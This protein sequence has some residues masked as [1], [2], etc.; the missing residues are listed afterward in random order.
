V[1]ARGRGVAA[2]I[3]VA[4]VS[5]SLA[6]GAQERAAPVVTSLTI[7]AGTPSGLWRS[8][9]WGGSWQK[10]RSRAEGDTL[11]GAGAVLS[12]LPGAPKVWL[13]TDTGLFVSED[14][15]F[16]WKRTDLKIP[17]HAVVPSRY[18]QA[19]P[20]VFVGTADG[21][22]KSE[23]AG[24]TFRPTLLKGVP[25][26]RIEWPGPDLV[27][28]TGSG[29]FVSPDGGRSVRTG[30]GLPAGPVHALA[31]SSYFA[32]DPVLFAGMSQGV[33]RSADGGA[34]WA[35]AGLE[36]HVVRDL[37]WL[38]PLLYAAA[39]DG[40]FRSPDAGAT[41]AKIGEGL[42]DRSPRRLL[43]PLA[44]ASGAEFFLGTDRGVL[45]TADGGER[46]QPTGALEE[47]VLALGT[48]PAPERTP[49]KK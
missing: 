1:T 29:V 32:A 41:W 3:A 4:L 17:V 28:A 49:G 14:F 21:L 26:T 36:D 39:D 46:W 8:E 25:V 15:G 34:R 48:F 47:P 27:M 7:F 37:V 30:T 45:R 20:T 42:K 23:D 11:E 6:T 18:P 9:D 22:L 24:R 12:I 35:P 2:A 13:G 19:D 44:P 40:L 33:F 38:G 10:A 5:W 31:L 16:G 43:F